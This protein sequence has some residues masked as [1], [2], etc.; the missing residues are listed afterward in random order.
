[1]VIFRWKLFG[2]RVTFTFAPVIE[3]VGV[4][5]RIDEN[6]HILMWDLDGQSLRAVVLRLKRVQGQFQLPT[7]SIL[8]SSR[9]PHFI[10]YCLKR[11]T[12]PEAFRIVAATQGIDLN[13][14]KYGVYRG[15][16]TLRVGFKHGVT[17]TLVARLPSKV[18]ADL[19][20]D[21]L[22]SWTRYETL[23]D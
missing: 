2:Y 22:K 17:P 1:M 19:D 11:C 10:A 3:T 6:H 13:F 23:K 8:Q 18:P 9:G 7:I 4:N 20:V 12:W 15:H 5:S 21:E 16:F 14:F